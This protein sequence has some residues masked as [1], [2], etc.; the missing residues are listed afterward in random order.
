[1]VD[2]RAASSQNRI[3]SF[4]CRRR[5]GFTT[6]RE[7]VNAEG[8]AAAT[9][10]SRISDLVARRIPAFTI[11][12]GIVFTVKKTPK[13]CLGKMSAQKYIQSGAQTG[14]HSQSADLRL[15]D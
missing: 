1:V 4:A 7:V 15:G 3:A 2:R 6:Y 5:I 12:R 8:R 14:S 11:C 9:A 13:L 10:L